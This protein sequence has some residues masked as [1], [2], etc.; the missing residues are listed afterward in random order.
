ML[1]ICKNNVKKPSNEIKRYL[2]KIIYSIKKNN[3]LYLTTLKKSERSDVLS[4]EEFFK[5]IYGSIVS[6]DVEL[7]LKIY[8]NEYI[9]YRH[10]LIILRSLVELIIEFKYLIHNSSCREKFIGDIEYELSDEFSVNDFRQLG[11]KRFKNGKISVLKMAED[12]GENKDSDEKLSL[13]SIYII[14]S[15]Q[16]HNL[17]LHEM[18]NKIGILEEDE[19]TEEFV[20][21]RDILI[22]YTLDPFMEAY[23]SK[24]SNV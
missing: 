15:E 22:V 2:K 23:M 9:S 4:S 3:S 8:K 16:V 17:A 12:I 5:I 6:E 19:Q 24:T 11:S 20:K 13:Y 7:F 1:K 21:D 10:S 14:L 18:I